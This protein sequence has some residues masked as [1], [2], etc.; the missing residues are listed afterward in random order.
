MSEN[1]DHLFGREPVGQQGNN[2][3]KIYAKNH[4]YFSDQNPAYFESKYIR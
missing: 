3:I 2:N 1:N 4:E